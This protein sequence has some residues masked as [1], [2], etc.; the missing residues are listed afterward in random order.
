MNENEQ[1]GL[2]RLDFKSILPIGFETLSDEDKRGVIKRL[3]DQDIELRREIGRKWHD[4]NIAENDLRV[5]IDTIERLEH[6]RK[7]Y[8][9][10]HKGQTGSGSY[11]LHIRGGDT[12]FIV[13]I[14]VA[15]GLIILGIIVI[16]ALR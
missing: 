9:V 16:L 1:R 2:Q 3:M 7:I 14:I 4:S 6:E 12:R 11:E 10:Q 5:A 8:S 15:V 13:P